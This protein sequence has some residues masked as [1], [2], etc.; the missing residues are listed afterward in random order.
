M[1]ELPEVE[2][3]KRGLQTILID[4]AISEVDFDWPKSFPNSK[5]DTELFLIGSK[6][7]DIER[8]GKAII[9][10]L[11]SDYSLAI[12]LKMTG[13]LVYRSEDFSFGAG[14]PNNSLIGSLPDSSTR[15]TISFVDGAKLYFNDQ[16]KFGWIRL[17]ANIELPNIDFFKKLG[18]D[19]LSN[20][21]TSKAFIDRLRRKKNSTIKAAI[22]DQ[23]TLA[24]VGN[25]YADEALWYAKIH[26]ATRVVEIPNRKLSKLLEG[27]KY[28][29][30]KSIESGGSSDRNYVNHEGKKGNYLNFAEV[31]R[32]NGQPCS[33][34]TTEILKIRVAGRGTHL[35]PRCQKR[36]KSDH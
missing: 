27:I 31:F 7:I 20:S 14:H 19:A 5:Q 15:V 6:I 30:T 33:R 36:A 29:M 28:V 16:R 21:L 23:S 22:L 35:C 34:C 17:I 25:I 4:K 18:P 24:G 26:P 3:I 1:P 32:K 9:I 8:K 12:H 13:Q 2:T 10:K 11:D